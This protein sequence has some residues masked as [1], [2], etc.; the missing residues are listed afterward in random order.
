MG[1]V[2]GEKIELDKG[3]EGQGLGTEKKK[4]RLDLPNFGEI[5]LP[6]LRKPQKKS[7]LVKEETELTLGSSKILPEEVV[8][9]SIEMHGGEVV[10]LLGPNGRENHDFLYDRWVC[11]S[12]R[13]KLK[14]NGQDITRLPPHKR[15]RVGLVYLSRNLL[16]LEN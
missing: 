14:I 1:I 15:A 12:L 13:G 9:V 8:G 7:K 11:Y 2:S 10:G 4:P 6:G 5:N 16:F 3:T